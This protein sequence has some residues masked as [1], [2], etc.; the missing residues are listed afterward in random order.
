M[1]H[2]YDELLQHEYSCYQLLPLQNPPHIFQDFQP[3]CEHRK[4][5]E[6]VREVPKQR[7]LQRLNYP[8]NVRPLRQYGQGQLQQILTVSHLLQNFQSLLTKLMEQFYFSF[9]SSL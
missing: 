5:N 2:E 7:Q 4:I 3:S 9:L 8:Q 6:F 1:L